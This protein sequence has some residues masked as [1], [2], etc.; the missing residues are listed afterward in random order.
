MLTLFN[1]YYMPGTLH[2]LSPILSVT[3]Q[4]TDYYIHFRDKRPEA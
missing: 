3:P 2:I 1:A 4:A